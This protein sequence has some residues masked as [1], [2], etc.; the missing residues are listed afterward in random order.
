VRSAFK[1]E[2][3]GELVHKEREPGGD[4]HIKRTGMLVGNVE[5]NPK[6]T[7]KKERYQ[8]SKKIHI[9]IFLRVLP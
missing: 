7:K 1:G 2:G 5:K 6:D 8:N 3:E 4:S 9:F